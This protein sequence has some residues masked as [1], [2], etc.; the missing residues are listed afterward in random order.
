[1]TLLIGC[2]L[3][4]KLLDKCVPSTG[5]EETSGEALVESELA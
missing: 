4:E 5:T 1:M 3:V 2:F